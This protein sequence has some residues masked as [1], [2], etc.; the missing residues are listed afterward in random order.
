MTCNHCGCNLSVRRVVKGTCLIFIWF[1][2]LCALQKVNRLSSEFLQNHPDGSLKH[3]AQTVWVGT[4]GPKCQ[5]LLNLSEETLTPF[6]S[7][8]APT[9]VLYI[10]ITHIFS[11]WRCLNPQHPRTLAPN[12]LRTSLMGP[13]FLAVAVNLELGDILVLVKK[14]EEEK[15]LH[16][17]AAWLLSHC[18]PGLFCLTQLILQSPLASQPAPLCFPDCC[19]QSQ[20]NL[21]DS[22]HRWSHLGDSKTISCSQPRDSYQSGCTAEQFSRLSGLLLRHLG[23]PPLCP[24]QCKP[25]F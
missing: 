4:H 8:P 10:S 1:S 23:V 24:L 25:H 21:S 2:I 5:M 13:V 16:S 19:L 3:I 6:S 20:P 17:F 7:L 18:P 11:S 12:T 15:C 22:S 9:K 14:E